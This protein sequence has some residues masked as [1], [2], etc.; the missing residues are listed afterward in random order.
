[1]HLELGVLDP[2][3]TRSNMCRQ[4]LLIVSKCTVER[5]KE[6]TMDLRIMTDIKVFP[7]DETF[8]QWTR[9]FPMVENIF[10]LIP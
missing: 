8:T 9:M 5:C 10:D 3:L 4:K 2:I 1:M 6:S 7:T